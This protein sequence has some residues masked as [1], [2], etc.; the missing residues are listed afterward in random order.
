MDSGNETRYIKMKNHLKTIGKT[1]L[2]AGLV[3]ASYFVGLNQNPIFSELPKKAQEAI[4][5][6]HQDLD[7]L[8][9]QAVDYYKR[10]NPRKALELYRQVEQEA[11]S[12]KIIDPRHEDIEA[13]LFQ[14]G[15]AIIDTDD[16]VTKHINPLYGHIVAGTP[17]RIAEY[18]T[19]PS[20]SWL[21]GQLE[22]IGPKSGTYHRLDGD[23]T[24][25]ASLL[26]YY[27]NSSLR[28]YDA[29]E[30]MRETLQSSPNKTDQIEWAIEILDKRMEQIKRDREWILN[31]K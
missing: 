29:Q 18:I 10:E 11:K 3:T 31:F 8:L 16:I 9:T 5:E 28:W 4:V 24:A 21:D 26:N 19:A 27:V 14:Y 22:V 7:T 20:L 23:K 30:R 25:Q 13:R 15:A 17:E 1:V 2:M 6:V 12:L